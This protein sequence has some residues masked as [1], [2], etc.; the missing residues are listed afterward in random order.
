M[1][2]KYANAW[3]QN[4]QKRKTSFDTD[5]KKERKQT[6]SEF[7]KSNKNVENFKNITLIRKQL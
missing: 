2:K 7:N 5:R 1:E 6:K 3:V 4:R